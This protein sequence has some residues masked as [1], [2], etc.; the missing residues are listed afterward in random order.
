MKIFIYEYI[1]SS[2]KN[3]IN[4]SKLINEAKIIIS[5]LVKDF[6]D[7]PDVNSIKISLQYRHF[8]YFNSLLDDNKISFVDS[9]NEAKTKYDMISKLE[10]S[11]PKIKLNVDLFA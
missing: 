11:L 1:L 4:N 3:Y 10:I 7:N 5:A 9:Y 2:N 6:I 8:K